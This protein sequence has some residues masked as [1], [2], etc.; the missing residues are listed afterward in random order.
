[1]LAGSG[2]TLSDYKPVFIRELGIVIVQDCSIYS[3]LW[4]WLAAVW[5]E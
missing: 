4:G 3:R 1:M 5:N 2:G